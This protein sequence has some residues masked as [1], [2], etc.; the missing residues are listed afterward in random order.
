MRYFIEF[1]FNGTKYHGWQ[2][3]PNALSV[4]EI[5]EY[6]LTILLKNRISVVGCGRTDSGVHAEQFFAHFDFDSPMDLVDLKYRLNVFLPL[7]VAIKSIFITENDVHAR[8]SALSRTYQYRISLTK[9]PFHQDTLLQFPFKN[10]DVSLMNKAA[11]TLL[12]Y[13]DFKCFS[14][15]RTDVKTFDCDISEAFWLQKGDLLVFQISANRFLRNMVRAIVGTLLDIGQNKLALEDLE[16]IIRSGD[17]SRAGAS[18]KAHGLFLTK[19]VYP[20]NSY[21][22]N[23]EV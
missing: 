16:N 4:Q 18:V 21:T 3:Q 1:S 22:T 19:I 23:G 7:D 2:S 9:D 8:F 12:N 17:R 15:S 20:F 14:R 5:L 13:T 11:K 6:A 10:L